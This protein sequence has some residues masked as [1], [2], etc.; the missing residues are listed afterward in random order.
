[1][2][3]TVVIALPKTEIVTGTTTANHLDVVAGVAAAGVA[4]T[5]IETESIGVAVLPLDLPRYETLLPCFLHVLSAP[6]NGS[7]SLVFSHCFTPSVSQLTVH[8]KL[9]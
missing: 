3:R 7:L 4:A 1:M 2:K 9:T 8:I 5:G 6:P